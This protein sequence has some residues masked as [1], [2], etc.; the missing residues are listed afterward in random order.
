M[1]KMKSIV[2]ILLIVVGILGIMG[3][4]VVVVRMRT[5]PAVPVY[6][7][8]FKAGD[9]TGTP[10]DTV[11]G[12][13]GFEGVIPGPEG[14]IAPDGMEFVR[15]AEEGGNRIF[16]EGRVLSFTENLV[17]VAEY[18]PKKIEQLRFEESEIFF[19][20]A[21]LVEARIIREPPI[22]RGDIR[23]YTD[24]DGVIQIV[25]YSNNGCVIGGKVKG[26][27]ILFA[28]YEG[29]MASVPVVVTD[30]HNEPYIIVPQRMILLIPGAEEIAL[31]RLWNGSVADMANFKWGL[32]RKNNAVTIKSSR[33]V[34][35]IKAN[36]LGTQVI[37][38]G[39]PLA[40]RGAEITVRVVP[41][42]ELPVYI[43]V[44]KTELVTGMVTE[45]DY[46]VIRVDL[47]GVEYDSGSD[48]KFTIEQ[49]EELCSIVGMKNSITVVPKARGEVL[50]EVTHPRAVY[51]RKIKVTIY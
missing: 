29:I 19:D 49:G 8:F 9:G 34:V 4:V 17:L 50:F 10:P 45:E 46:P 28:E 43:R 15:W 37:T 20:I 11:T 39:H 18:W 2:R 16:E 40:K 31:V 21:E 7:V 35:T 38:V 44:D 26:D 30:E 6:T 23:Y 48:F 22:G 25:E 1:G 42:E 41:M 13:A 24:G 27:A 5:G 51:P 36:E 32:G 14:L 47:I 33:N 3:A 12:E